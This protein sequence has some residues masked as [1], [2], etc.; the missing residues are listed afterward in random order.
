VDHGVGAAQRVAKR[1]RIAEVA[2][3]KLHPNPVRPQ[4]AG[5]AD[6]GSDGL[7]RLD[8]GRQKGLADG[9]RCA[10]DR[11]HA[12]TLVVALTAGLVPLFAYNLPLRSTGK[13]G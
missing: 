9:A 2:E 4:P 5:V 8:Q 3:R 13:S 12:G 11:D 10:G 1:V 6:E 7:S